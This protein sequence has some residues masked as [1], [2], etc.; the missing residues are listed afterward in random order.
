MPPAIT[1]PHPSS[2]ST[3]VAWFPQAW[4]PRVRVIRS[5]GIP[6][7]TSTTTKAAARAK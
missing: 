6:E 4:V 1:A 5:P 2:I 3:K 7:F